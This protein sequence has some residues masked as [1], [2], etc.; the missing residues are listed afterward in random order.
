MLN[1]KKIVSK[2][3]ERTYFCKDF[4]TNSNHVPLRN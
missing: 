3:T 2:N 4:K 1:I